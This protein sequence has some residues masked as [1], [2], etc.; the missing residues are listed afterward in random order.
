MFGGSMKRWLA[1]ALL[2]PSLALADA[3]TVTDIRIQGL[4]RVSAGTVFN[5]LPVNVGDQVDEATVRQLIRLLF[6]SGY[7][8]RRSIAARRQRADRHRRRT[9]RNRLDRTQGQQV[10]QDRRADGRSRQ[11][12]SQ[13]RRDL[14]AVDART[15]RP[16]TGT[17]VRRARS[18]RREHR[19]QRRRTAAQP[20]RHPHRYQGRQD[21][22]R[23][24]TSTSSAIT[25]SAKPICSTFSN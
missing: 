16:R 22:R 3:F 15:R 13:G 25:R 7:F 12:G 8:P 4:Q 5:L 23:S 20:R 14:Q 1:I 6:Q 9:S 10:D 19:H 2:W 17:P 18:L 21:V 24:S 11:A